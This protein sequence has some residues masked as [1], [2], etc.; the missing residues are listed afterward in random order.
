MSTLFILIERG[1]EYSDKWTRNHMVSDSKTFLEGV[2][3]AIKRNRTAYNRNMAELDNAFRDEHEAWFI[4]H[5]NR[6]D[7]KQK[8]KWKS[9]LRK[10]DITA[11]MQAEREAVQKHNDELFEFNAQNSHNFYEY[12]KPLRD[13][14]IAKYEPLQYVRSYV[15]DWNS[16]RL[17]GEIDADTNFYIEEIAFEKS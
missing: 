4:K 1:G 15:S 3:I 8:P 5:P 10:E 16:D 12:W 11:D 2:Q 7:Y 9:G 14:M 17:N 13:A 6:Q